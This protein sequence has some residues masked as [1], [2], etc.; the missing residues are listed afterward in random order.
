MAL[1]SNTLAV[2]RQYLSAAVD[3]LKLSTVASATAGTIYVDTML[4]EGNDYYNDH[5]YRAYCYG[6]SAIGQEREVDDFT[7]V[8]TIS[9][10]PAFNPAFVNGDT[11]E[12]HH[13]FTEDEYCK[14]INLAIEST[15]DG[16]YLIGKTD[17]TTT[18]VAGQ[19]EYTLPTTM[20]Y[21]HRITTEETVGGGIFEESAVIDPRDYRLISSRKL[22]LDERYT[23]TADKDLRIE[24]QGVQTAATA[25]T[26]VI[27]LPIDW[28]VQKAI[29][30]LPQAKIQSNKLDNTY[31][32]AFALSAVIPKNWPNPRSQKV[33]E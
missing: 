29:T 11:M 14:A 27:K 13:V 2:T 30:F 19:Y 23:V 12:L 1:Y 32:Q 6:G 16:L 17:E 25:D 10:Q 31:R 20:Y 5:K 33:V 21:I 18:L 28:L 8:G 4:R 24:G 9:F 26:D 22:K 7:S 15:K 3:D